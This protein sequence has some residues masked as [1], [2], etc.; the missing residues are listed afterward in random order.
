MH[1]LTSRL[2]FWHLGVLV[3]VVAVLEATT[4]LPGWSWVPVYGGAALLFGLTMVGAIDRGAGPAR[5]REVWTRRIT[6]ELH[7]PAPAPGA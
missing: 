6:S 3:V 1:R 7:A 4:G 2:R 5:L